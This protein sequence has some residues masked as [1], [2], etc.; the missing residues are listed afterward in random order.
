MPGRRRRI[1]SAIPRASFSF[2]P[3]PGDDPAD[4]L[5]P[6]ADEEFGNIADGAGLNAAATGLIV[7][8][9]YLVWP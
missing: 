4:G 7:A 9:D 5:V 2:P 1:S 3:S 8:F 6:M